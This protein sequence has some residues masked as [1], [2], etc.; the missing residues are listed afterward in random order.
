MGNLI[1]FLEGKKTYIVA[2][3]GAALAFANAIGYVVPEW[4]FPLLGALGLGTLRA[5]VSRA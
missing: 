4:V 2:L 3:I 5:A 1:A